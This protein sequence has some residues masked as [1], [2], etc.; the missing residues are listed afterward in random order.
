MTKNKKDEEFYQYL[1]EWFADEETHSKIK[2]INFLLEWIGEKFYF[3]YSEQM[4][5][6]DFEK[7][8]FEDLHLKTVGDLTED[9]IIAALK[10]L[11]VR[12]IND[13]LHGIDIRTKKN[14][15]TEK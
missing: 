1:S 8:Y 6:S 12:K 9:D 5:Y 10:I 7:M 3:N 4:N 2:Q 13:K 14:S 11:R 15:Q